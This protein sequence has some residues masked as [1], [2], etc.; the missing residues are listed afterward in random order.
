MSSKLVGGNFDEASVSL[1]PSSLADGVELCFTFDRIVAF[2]LL[3]PRLLK[4]ISLGKQVLEDS[5]VL[6]APTFFKLKEI[7]QSFMTDHSPLR[8]I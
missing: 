7:A 5:I 4:N 2:I 6:Y 1:M 3:R 8:I